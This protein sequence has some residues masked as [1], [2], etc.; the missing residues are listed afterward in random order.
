MFVCFPTRYVWDTDLKPQKFGMG[1]YFSPAMVIINRGQGPVIA[2]SPAG[3]GVGEGAS[4][5]SQLG[6]SE[7]W[8]IGGDISSQ[9]QVFFIYDHGL[10]SYVVV[11]CPFTFDRAFLGRGSFSC[12]CWWW[13]SC[14]SVLVCPCGSLCCKEMMR[15]NI[16]Y[17]YFFVLLDFRHLFMSTFAWWICRKSPSSSPPESLQNPI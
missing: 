10:L 7:M 16:P 9:G 12:C 13:S 3:I 17:N 5:K 6:S 15:Y 11:I 1:Y 4:G 2:G 8:W 14:G